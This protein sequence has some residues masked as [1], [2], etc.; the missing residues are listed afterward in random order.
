MG[1]SIGTTAVKLTTQNEMT[2]G[3]NQAAGE[4]SSW[5]GK[6][7]KSAGAGSLGGGI[8]SAITGGLANLG[9]V[10]G[11]AGAS[12]TKL[13]SGALGGALSGGMVGGPAGA[14]IGG[15]AGA[16]TAA[17]GELV[18]GLNDLTEKFKEQK[19]AAATLGLSVQSVQGLGYAAE[20]SGLQ[21]DEFV[22]SFAKLEK[23]IDEAKGGAN[24]QRAAFAQLG[25]SLEDLQSLTPEEIFLKLAD[26][27]AESEDP[28][29]KATEAMLLMG[30]SGFQMLPLLNK[31]SEG[32]NALRLQAQQLGIEM[33]DQQVGAMEDY[34]KSMGDLNAAW[35]GAK[36]KI[37]TAMVPAITA[38]I[39]A[40]TDFITH[41]ERMKV[42]I[43]QW[44][45]DKVTGAAEAIGLVPEGT[46]AMNRD[47]A[48]QELGA[49]TRDENDALKKQIE[50]GKLRKER[51]K[52]NHPPTESSATGNIE[53]ITKAWAIVG[54]DAGT[55]FKEE[56]EALNKAHDFGLSD[57]DLSLGVFNAGQKLIQ[58]MGKATQT[59]TAAQK[60]SKEAVETI[61]R[62]QSPV[63]SPADALKNAM[64]QSLAVQTSHR[65][66]GQ[67]MLGAL[68]RMAGKKTEV[69]P[70][71][72]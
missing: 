22:H 65:D 62:A 50:E 41:F 28:S 6:M 18:G 26:S 15:A 48:R 36:I 72:P 11:P 51:D 43:R 70:L 38:V 17:I 64:D 25:I 20:R 33:T 54:K 66:I 55:L 10:T 13:F 59:T 23:S 3:L 5:L 31:G 19:R 68:N 56:I 46:Q 14:L 49:I 67:Q 57:A 2:T 29:A 34:K 7:A 47:L 30:K 60:D 40:V 52:Q 27:I 45:E 37:I 53:A 9:S 58:A 71:G 42:S 39:K 61:I 24:Q 44:I 1:L 12:L 16:G 35:E 8:A 63:T 32:I 69:V 21:S 4:Y